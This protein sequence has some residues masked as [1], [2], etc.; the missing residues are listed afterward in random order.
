MERIISKNFA[1]FVFFCTALTPCTVIAAGTWDFS[2]E[3]YLLAASIEGDASVG[4]AAGAEVDL[5]A[6]DIFENLKAGG[7]IHFEMYSP[8]DMGL[9]LDYGY[10]RLGAD[11]VNALGGILDA[12]VRQSI[13]ELFGAKRFEMQGGYFS[14][15]GGIRHWN[16][17]VRIFVDPAILAGSAT[18]EI[19][20][21]WTDPVVG[22][23]L[24]KEL[25]LDWRLVLRGDVGGF[26]VSS[27][28]SS[29]LSAAIYYSFNEL[30]S[31]DIQY[32]ALWVDYED[33]TRGTPGY[34]AYDTV[35]HG[36]VIG[37]I[38]EF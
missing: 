26:G 5:D 9:M 37:V 20:E 30:V 22:I 32:K 1:L 14:I 4:R 18:A 6:G 10:M 28:F 27:D 8:E 29:L 31:L 2:I 35:T 21:D 36:P 12:K 38:F 17:D 16:N 25:G 15:Y 19:D 7:M 3:P 13:F 33:G 23:R 34:F 24:M 11:K